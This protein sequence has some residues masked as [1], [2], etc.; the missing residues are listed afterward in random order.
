MLTITPT[1]SAENSL[2]DIVED[3][4]VGGN[5]DDGDNKMIERSPFSKKSNVSTKY[6]T[7]LRSNADSVPFEKRWAH[8]IIL[9]IIEASSSKHYMESYKIKLL[10][11]P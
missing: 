3:A 1:Q 11:G 4:E 7:S 9:I 2:L 5:G 8:L 10:L 6:L